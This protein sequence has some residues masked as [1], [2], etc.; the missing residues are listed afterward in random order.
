MR[1]GSVWMRAAACS[2]LVFAS[3]AIG[4][5]VAAHPAVAAVAHDNEVYAFGSATFHGSSSAVAL[6]RPVVAMATTADGKGY[7]QVAS[8]GGIFSFN[9]PFYGALAGWPLIQPV[10]GMTA[11][12]SGH[13]YW[14][15]TADG[16]VFP[17][18]YAH[19]YGSLTRVP[20]TAPIKSLIPGPLRPR[21]W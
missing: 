6:S 2:V 14:I 17:F 13:G 11:T 1:R 3:G 18:G 8:D 19:F 5:V 7:W 15:V 10:V 16:A 21:F 9:A 20:L 12:P 4:S